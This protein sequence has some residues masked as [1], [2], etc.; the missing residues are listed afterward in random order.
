MSL[1]YALLALLTGSPMTGYEVSKR[2]GASVGRVWHAPDSQI[3]PE[4]RRLESAGLLAGTAVPWGRSSTKTRYTVTPAGLAAFREWIEQP[5]RP[6]RE[7][8]PAYLRAA[9]LDWAS[10]EAA[11]AHLRE[12]RA[13]HA[14][15][16]AVLEATRAALLDLTHPTLAARLEHVPRAQWDRIVAFRVYAYDGMIARERAALEWV[17]QGFALVE[18]HADARRLDPPRE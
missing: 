15:H 8:D 1:R 11:R 13:F 6:V 5:Q 14:E 10:P 18:A 3:Y 7:R 12:L 17:E 4:L 16:L 2:F 9:Y